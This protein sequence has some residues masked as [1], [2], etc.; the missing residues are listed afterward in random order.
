MPQLWWIDAICIDQTVEALDERSNQVRM[1]SEIYTT[2]HET[3]AWMGDGNSSTKSCMRIPGLLGPISRSRIYQATKQDLIPKLLALVG[4]SEELHTHGLRALIKN[5]YFERV[6][7]LQELCLSPRSS[8]QCCTTKISWRAFGNGAL[9]LLEMRTLDHIHDGRYYEGVFFYRMLWA[10]LRHSKDTEVLRSP[11]SLPLEP[12]LL[13]PFTV[14]LKATDSK[15]KVFALYGIFQRLFISV[16]LPDYTDSI[17]RIY[18][19]IAFSAIMMTETLQILESVDSEMRLADLPSWVPD[20]SAHDPY[21]RLPR[22]R[23]RA[24][25]WSTPEARRLDDRRTLTLRGK[26]VGNIRDRGVPM[27]KHSAEGGGSP[28]TPASLYCITVLQEW[29]RFAVSP[30]V[31]DDEFSVLR[32]PLFEILDEINVPKHPHE[33]ALDERII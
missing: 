22:L 24:S 14:S 8:V 6:W 31:Y 16:P 3:V 18:A 19:E 33:K 20:W 5:E 26:V 12:L 32:H 9:S 7:T 11:Y 13:L 15:D 28:F 10:W 2:A 1:M 27:L 23:T 21:M 30:D 17:C 29:I 4:Y 25:K